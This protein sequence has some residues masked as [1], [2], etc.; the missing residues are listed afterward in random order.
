MTRRIYIA[1]VT[2]GNGRNFLSH[3]CFSSIDVDQFVRDAYSEVKNAQ[4]DEHDGTIIEYF[5][6]P[7]KCFSLVQR[8]SIARERKGFTIVCAFELLF[9]HVSFR[10]N[11]SAVICVLERWHLQFRIGY[12]RF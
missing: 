5:C 11:I 7:W 10:P 12:L 9:I 3:N 2:R 8:H 1:R 4:I 6:I